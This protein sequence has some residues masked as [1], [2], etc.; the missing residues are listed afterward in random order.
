MKKSEM[1]DVQIRN[2]TL[3][4][5][6]SLLV[7]TESAPGSRPGTAGALIA[8][9]K[10]FISQVKKFHVRRSKIFHVSKCSCLLH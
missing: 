9:S 6:P 1:K 4:S 8:S 3:T 2:L 5:I 10:Q 7:A